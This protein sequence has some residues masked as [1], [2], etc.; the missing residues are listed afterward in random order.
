MIS[1]KEVSRPVEF[2]H[3]CAVALHVS[4]KCVAWLSSHYQ[5]SLLAQHNWTISCM[6]RDQL[7]IV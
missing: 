2:V 1:Q 3:T 4:K 6:T 7:S 5:L